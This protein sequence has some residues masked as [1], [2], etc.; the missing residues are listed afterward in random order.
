M[1][2]WGAR[3]REC[4]GE[5]RSA[6]VRSGQ[7]ESGV[8]GASQ[9]LGVVNRKRGDRWEDDTGQ[10]VNFLEPGDKLIGHGEVT[11]CRPLALDQPRIPILPR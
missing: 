2:G 11:P 7:V 5:G 8:P 4:R 10:K 1:Q 6:E 3:E 9:R